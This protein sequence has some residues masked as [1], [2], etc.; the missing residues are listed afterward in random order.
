MSAALSGRWH[1]T[2]LGIRTC[3]G[4]IKEAS[5]TPIGSKDYRSYIQVAQQEVLMRLLL[6]S[7]RA[8]QAHVPASTPTFPN[9]AVFLPSLIIASSFTHQYPLEVISDQ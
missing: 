8:C 9:L 4:Y 6:L 5:S 1:W 3:N 7:M 2:G